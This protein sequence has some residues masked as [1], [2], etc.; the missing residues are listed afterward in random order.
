MES[1]RDTLTHAPRH[2][3]IDYLSKDGLALSYVLPKY[4]YDREVILT[5][6]KNNP[7]AFLFIMNIYNDDKEI[8][9]EV[10]KK[11]GYFL[12]YLSDNLRDDK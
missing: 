2:Q 4:V 6:I 7:K 12:R 10:I 5:A 9:F 8:C 1:I 11:Y 3:I